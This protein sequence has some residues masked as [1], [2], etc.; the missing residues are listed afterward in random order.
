MNLAAIVCMVLGSL[1]VVVV[2]PWRFWW[3][4]RLCPQCKELLPRWNIWGWKDDW[5]CRRCGCQINH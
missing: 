2:R 4:R 1:A 3:S 5:T